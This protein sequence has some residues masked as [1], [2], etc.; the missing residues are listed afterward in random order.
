MITAMPLA[1]TAAGLRKL[2]DAIDASG[3]DVPVHV[4]LTFTPS[5]FA[6]E[7][8]CVAGVD[9]IAAVFGLSAVSTKQN[10]TWYHEATEDRDGVDLRIYTLIRPP[11]QRCACG[12]ECTHGAVTS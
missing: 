11:A 2:A 9:Q 1:A 8:A 3:V 12:A 5:F 4:Y 7:A 6:D 10:S